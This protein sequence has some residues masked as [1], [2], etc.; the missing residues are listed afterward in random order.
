MWKRFV[1][2]IKDFSISFETPWNIKE[3]PKVER[4]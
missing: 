1:Q 3:A 4:K 2:N